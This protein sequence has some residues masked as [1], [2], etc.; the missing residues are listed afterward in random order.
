[1]LPTG[2][3][4]EGFGTG[5]TDYFAGLDVTYDADS[6]V[7]SGTLGYQMTDDSTGFEFN[8]PWSVGVSATARLGGDAYVG[9]ALDAREAITTEADDN[10]DL[11][12]YAGRPLAG[13]VS[14]GAHVF[15]GFTDASADLGAG[16]T[17]SL[18][19]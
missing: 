2:D 6:I 9:A 11:T 1:E 4:D 16:L 14:I 8:D 17:L 10:L 12:L 3:E 15:T 7:W 19:R 13:S 18:S 5:G